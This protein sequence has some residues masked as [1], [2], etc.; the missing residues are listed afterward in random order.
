MVQGEARKD[1]GREKNWR[2]NRT[3]KRFS[4]RGKVKVQENFRAMSSRRLTVPDSRKGRTCLIFLLRSRS[5]S[6]SRS[7]P[8]LVK[9]E[10]N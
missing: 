1:L 9:I 6:F 8:P 3:A 2:D 10:D 4:K 5:F 7:R